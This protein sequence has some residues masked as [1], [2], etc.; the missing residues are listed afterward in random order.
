MGKG[1]EKEGKK[2]VDKHTRCFKPWAG[3]FCSKS[4]W[5]ISSY[6][7]QCFCC[8]SMNFGR[9][10]IHSK[11][12]LSSNF[13]VKYPNLRNQKLIYFLSKLIFSKPSNLK[14]QKPNKGNKM[15]PHDRIYMLENDF[16]KYFPKHSGRQSNWL[17][18]KFCWP[19]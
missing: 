7:T 13:I 3:K 9:A 4:W 1:G 2:K 12:K 14:W 6:S 15:Y 16:K 11:R 8:I 5:S 10:L 19:A 17:C 18:F